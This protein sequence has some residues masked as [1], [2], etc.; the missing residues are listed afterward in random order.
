MKHFYKII[1]YNIPIVRDMIKY[2]TRNVFIQYTSHT[3]K[4]LMV[5][6]DAITC[7]K[8]FFIQSVERV[9]IFNFL[10]TFEDFI[11]KCMINIDL[12]YD[13]GFTYVTFSS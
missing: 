3:R 10:Y 9:I 6:T 13:L 12:G 4:Y 1:G 5:I 7:K 2:C 8:H 11:L